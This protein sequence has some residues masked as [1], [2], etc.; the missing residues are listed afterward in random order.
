MRSA[1]AAVD[2]AASRPSPADRF[3][4]DREGPAKRAG[5]LRALQQRFQKLNEYC[6]ETVAEIRASLERTSPR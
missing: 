1:L 6:D 4:I 3:N 5:K 2:A